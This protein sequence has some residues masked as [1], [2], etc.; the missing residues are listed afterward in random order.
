M[1]EE[2][3][4]A[5]FFVA[6]LVKRYG[7]LENDSRERFAASLTSV[8]FE[9]YKNHWNPSAPTRGQA[10]RYGE[11]SAPF[12][13]SAV[14]RRDGGEFS[15]RIHDAVERASFDVQ[16]GSSSDEE[17]VGGDNSMNSSSSIQSAPCSAPNPPTTEPK[18]IPT[19]SN[20]NSV[21]RFSEFSPGAPQTW[22]RDKRKLFSG[23]ALV[24]HPAAPGAPSSQKVFKSYRATFSFSGPRVDKYHWVSKSRS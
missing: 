4:A 20:P 6:R 9:N 22:L 13:V 18:T 14:D 7:V 19:V 8:L 24:P 1:K 12:C 10:Y 2:I 23:E 5:V 16:S 15:R 3:A 21:Y 17:E 11:R